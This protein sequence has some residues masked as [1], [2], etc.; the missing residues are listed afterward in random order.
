MLKPLSDWVI[1][2][3]D[4]PEGVLSVEQSTREDVHFATF[5]DGPEDMRYLRDSLVGFLWRAASKVCL[6]G[7]F[8]LVLKRTDVIV[9]EG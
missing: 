1:L 4:R 8:F 2:R 7:K 9:T 6:N 5:V 3:E